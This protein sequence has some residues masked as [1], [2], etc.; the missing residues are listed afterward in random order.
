MYELLDVAIRILKQEG[1]A[2]EDPWDLVDAFEEKIAEYAG[3][4][5]GVAVDSCTN[6]LF[7]CLKYLEAQDE[8]EIPSRTYISVP[9]L[10]IHAGCRPRFKDYEW[11]GIYQLE[12]YP[13]YDGATRFTKGMYI[14]DAYQC[15][16]FH[17]RKILPITKGGMI[18][19]DDSE[20]VE[21]FKLARYEGRD[22]RIPHARMGEPNILGWNMYMPPE[23]AARGIALFQDLPK[24]NEDSGGAH[25]YKDISGYKLWE[26]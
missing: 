10:I 1:R 22:Y 12:P 18:L 3:S 6:A 20:A 23:Q 11:S 8:I 5:Y 17:I 13:V 9:G 4:N 24:C 26:K 15:L 14:A 7:L 16:S 21:W 2:V 25:T 19:T